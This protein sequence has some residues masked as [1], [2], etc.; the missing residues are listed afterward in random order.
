MSNWIGLGIII[1][2][3]L[4]AV[5]GLHLLSK[6]YDVTAEEF[7][8]RA[9]E[10]PGLLNAGIIGLQKVLEPQVEKAAAV[11]EDFRQGHYDGEQESGDDNDKAKVKM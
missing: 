6:P 4:C 5:G 1:F 3:L 8:R 9:R 10:E 7:E 11:Q 2:I